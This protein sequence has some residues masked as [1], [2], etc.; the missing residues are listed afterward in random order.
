M[1]KNHCFFVFQNHYYFYLTFTRSTNSVFW[2][3]LYAGERK[4]ACLF[5][6]L[7]SLLLEGEDTLKYLCLSVPVRPWT[8]AQVQFFCS[9]PEIP[10][11]RKFSQKNK[12]IK[13]IKSVNVSWNLLCRLIRICR[14]QWWC[15]LFPFLTGNTLFG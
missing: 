9:L 14:I 4:L 2:W 15:S 5:K 6:L 3:N 7:L 1:G 10:F 13:K 8:H 11:L 12:K